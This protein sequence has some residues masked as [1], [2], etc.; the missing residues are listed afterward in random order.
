MRR[1]R[2]VPPAAPEHL[3]VFNPA[4][5][6]GPGIGDALA[7]WK[8]ARRAWCAERGYCRPGARCAGRPGPLGS[9]PGMLRAERA[10]R[11]GLEQARV[12]DW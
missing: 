5:W 3:A 11:L 7:A 6:P 4:D 10:A 9:C 12:R 2:P 1:R 8:T